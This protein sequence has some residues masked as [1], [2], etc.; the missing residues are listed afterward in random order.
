MLAPLCGILWAICEEE[1]PHVAHFSEV[2]GSVCTLG[3]FSLPFYAT[4]KWNRTFWRDF[5]PKR[6]RAQQ[7]PGPNLRRSD[8]FC[9]GLMMGRAY[10]TVSVVSFVLLSHVLR[11]QGAIRCT[12][13][14]PVLAELP[15]GVSNLSECVLECTGMTYFKKLR[16]QDKRTIKF[17]ICTEGEA[18]SCSFSVFH[19]LSFRLWK[20]YRC[21]CFIAH[22]CCFRALIQS[23]LSRTPWWLLLAQG[24]HLHR[25]GTPAARLRH[26][27]CEHVCGGTRDAGGERHVPHRLQA[28]G[29]R[30]PHHHRGG[31]RPP[32]R[33]HAALH[34]GGRGD[35][36]LPAGRRQ[37]RRPRT[38][39]PEVSTL[40]GHFLA[41]KLSPPTRL[42]WIKCQ[43]WIGKMSRGTAT[44]FKNRPS[45]ISVISHRRCC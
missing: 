22:R 21:A 35:V 33:G 24:S 43:G 32:V 16:L 28:P 41:E 27:T 12:E 18:S 7:D 20:F 6:Q 31:L 13:P 1:E 38:P 23:S 40:S 44:T 2:R 9:V 42:R 39:S 3:T 45:S 10:L 15:D 36:S 19:F 26:V 29:P 30:R 34:R 14:K 5:T 8:R 4:V 11:V 37:Q 25:R 17:Q